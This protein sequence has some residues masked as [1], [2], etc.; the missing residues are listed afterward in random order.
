MLIIFIYLAH[1][2]NKTPALRT[3]LSITTRRLNEG[4][5]GE[6]TRLWR[7]MP[8][9]VTGLRSL[10]PTLAPAKQAEDYKI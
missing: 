6:Y 1:L 4:G 10:L 5:V 2:V 8:P 7:R 3:I 9:E